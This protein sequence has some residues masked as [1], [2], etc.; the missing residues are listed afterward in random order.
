MNPNFDVTSDKNGNK[1]NTPQ[2]IVPN[3]TPPK[4]NNIIHGNF[5]EIQPATFCTKFGASH[6]NNNQ[7]TATNIKVASKAST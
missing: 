7:A 5:L 1:I 3:I 2:I 4:P 6:V